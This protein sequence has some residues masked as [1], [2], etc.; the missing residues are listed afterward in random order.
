MVNLN[1]GKKEIHKHILYKWWI[2]TINNM[3]LFSATCIRRS[4]SKDV[5]FKSPFFKQLTKIPWLFGELS[6]RYILD[7]YLFFLRKTK[8]TVLVLGVSLTIVEWTSRCEVHLQTFVFLPHQTWMT[9]FQGLFGSKSPSCYCTKCHLRI[10][11]NF[12]I[13]KKTLIFI[14]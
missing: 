7:I 4:P 8:L 1:S 10:T 2:F 5:F 3:A 14:L 12:Y 9:S 13:F 6:I 11:F